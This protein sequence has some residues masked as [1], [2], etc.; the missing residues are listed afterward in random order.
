V[1]YII[2]FDSVRNILIVVCKNKVG[3]VI[4]RI[5][6]T[7]P[8]ALDTSGNVGSSELF[9]LAGYCATKTELPK[10]ENMWIL[11]DVDWA[12]AITAASSLDM[13]NPS[14]F[15]DDEVMVFNLY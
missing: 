10:H 5:S 14:D 3:K 4:W 2:E 7:D 11:D 15:M 1:Q 9:F 13:G 6:G 8:A 12:A